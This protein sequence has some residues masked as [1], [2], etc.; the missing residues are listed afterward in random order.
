MGT[1]TPDLPQVAPASFQGARPLA[2]ITLP[3]LQPGH[4]LQGASFQP[5]ADPLHPGLLLHV[6]LVSS[7]MR[8]VE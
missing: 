7:P 1:R 8:C 2:R 5:P 3:T 4:D 6:G